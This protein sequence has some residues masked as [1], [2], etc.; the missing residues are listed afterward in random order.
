MT[1]V[2]AGLFPRRHAGISRAWPNQFPFRLLFERMREPAREAAGGEHHE[3]GRGGQIVGV[4][5]G[6]EHEVDVGMLAA[7]VFGGGDECVEFAHDRCVCMLRAQTGEQFGGARVAVRVERVA[8]AGE[9]VAALQ[10]GFDEVAWRCGVA[11]VGD[12]RVGACGRATVARARERGQA[13]AHGRMQMRAGGRDHACGECG[14]VEFVIGAQHERGAD[15]IGETCVAGFP[16]IGE[17]GMHRR[18]RR[19]AADQQRGV[20]AEQGGGDVVARALRGIQGAARAGCE[21]RDRGHR[22]LQ[23]R[24]CGVGGNGGDVRGPGVVFAMDERVVCAAVPEQACGVFERG[25]VADG[26]DCGSSAVVG[27][28]RTDQRD[29]RLQHRQAAV[30]AVRGGGGGASTHLLALRQALHVEPRVEPG[31][32]VGAG[33]GFEQ[34]AADVGVEGRL[35]DAEQRAGLAGGE[36]VGH[37]DRL[38]DPIK[39]DQPSWW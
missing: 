26:R 37:G 34:A 22:A 15:E 12:E 39:I 4:T 28:V 17:Q 27:A 10:A 21:Q 19:R 9:I 11:R 25:A 30:E 24:Q 1:G 35:A 6:G 38:I 14:D 8:E 20:V 31:A 23:R 2:L 16:D 7:D 5:D 29:P 33:P 13:G 32:M 36:Q 18:R 3:C